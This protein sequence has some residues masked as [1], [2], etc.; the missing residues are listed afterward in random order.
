MKNRLI[1]RFISAITGLAFVFSVCHCS[2]DSIIRTDSAL[3]STSVAESRHTAVGT[4]SGLENQFNYQDDMEVPY[5]RKSW[6]QPREWNSPKIDPKDYKGGIMIYFDKIGLEPEYARGK[7]QRIYCSI[8]GATEPISSLKFHIFY[9]TRLTVKENADGEFITAGRGLNSF[10]TGSSMIEE[11]KLVF[12]AVSENTD[13][14][15]SCLFTIDFIVPE[16]ADQGELYP[17]GISYVDDGIAYDT[18]INSEQDDAGKLQMTYVFTKGIYNGYI[19]MN[20][21]KKTTTATTVTTTTTTTAYISPD[22]YT[23]GDVNGDGRINAVDASLVLAYYARISTNQEG[24]Y[25]QK[26]RLAADVNFDG[27]INAVDASN[28]LAYYAYSSTEKGTP[29]TL[30]EFMAAGRQQ[31][32]DNR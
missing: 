16:N 26:Q 4:D 3:Y 23:L 15:Q 8:T 14:D 30:E 6:I 29:V 19:R 2:P 12:Y 20:G 17:F 5:D 18:F 24:G 1:N 10:T 28:I 7:V 25:D 22:E 13:L 27:V 11:G 31:R 21:E 9:D 32:S